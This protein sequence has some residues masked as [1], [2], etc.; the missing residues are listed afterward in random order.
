METLNRAG[1]AAGAPTGETERGRENNWEEE[2]RSAWL[3]FV[4][5]SIL[6]WL[7]D[8]KVGLF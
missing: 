8:G 3:G 1:A 2:P 7:K 4:E 5:D 6:M